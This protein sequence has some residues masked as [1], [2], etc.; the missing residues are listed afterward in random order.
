MARYV[1]GFV[2]PMPKKSLKKYKKMA[3]L[4]KR[5]WMKHGALDYYECVSDD[6]E[7]HPGFKKMCKL[8][9]TEVVVFAYIVYESKGHRNRVNKAVM[10]EFSTMG[11]MPDD[12]FNMSRFAVGGFK[13]L[14]SS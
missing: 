6:L 9:P 2:I 13:V 3:Q 12:L 1:D 8:K 10:K 5:T 7:S 14:V 4:G 11:P